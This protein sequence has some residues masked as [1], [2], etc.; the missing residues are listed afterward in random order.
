[1][2]GTHALCR[3]DTDGPHLKICSAAYCSSMMVLA[4]DDAA[5]GDHRERGIDR[6]F[7]HLDVLA[8][9]G[10]AAA[11]ADPHRGVILGDEEVQLLRDRTRAHEGFEYLAHVVQSIADFLFRLRANPL[12][13]SLVV[14]HAGG[15]LDQEIVMTVQDRPAGGTVASAPRCGLRHCTATASRH[16]RG[17]KLRASASAIRRCR[18]DSRTSTSFNR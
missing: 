9:V 10:E 14:E 18:G 16:D 7:Q 13:G 8:F 1:M 2:V 5:V 11:A 3:D 6:Q 17:R 12:L 4:S 15:G